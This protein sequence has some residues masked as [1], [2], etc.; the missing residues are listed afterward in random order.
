MAK[1][2]SVIVPFYS[3]T[4]DDTHCFQAA[5]RMVLKYF[6]PGQDFSW[7]ELDRMSAKLDGKPTWPARM[8]INLHN[9]GFDIA[10][11]QGED[12]KAFIK[13]G[14]DYLKRVVG[15][16]KAAW[17]IANSD[18]PREQK[19]CQELL[20]SGVLVENRLPNVE[21]IR[22]FLDKGYLVK[23]TINSRVLRGREGY[24]GH[25]VVI[26]N[27]DSINIT[28]HD[29]GLPASKACTLSHRDFLAAWASPDA[30]SK[31]LTAI[32]YLGAHHG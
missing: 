6:L 26:Y 11:A 29:P 27:V 28:M 16:E 2:Q 25:A 9:M 5:M 13:E 15:E 14:G 18:I 4:V 3:N 31:N 23:C 30:T 10:I 24:V 32:K 8:L 1:T 17:E 19:I 22:H 21:D 7:R 12:V 20:D